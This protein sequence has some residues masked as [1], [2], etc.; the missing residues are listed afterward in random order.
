MSVGRWIA[1]LAV[2]VL[3]V[4]VVLATNSSTTQETTSSTTQ[5]MTSST[6]T[7]AT[8]STTEE[9]F[10]PD[11]ALARLPGRLLVIQA[12]GRLINMKP[13]GT[14]RLTVAEA[15]DAV[16]ERSLPAWSPNGDR[17]AWVDRFADEQIFLVIATASGEA[18]SRFKLALVPGYIAWR[19][20]GDMIAFIGDDGRANQVLRILDIASGEVSHLEDG[21]PLYFDWDPDG[22]FL[23]VHSAGTLSRIPVDGSEVAVLPPDGEFRVPVI[24]GEDMVVGFNRDIGEALSVANL[25]GE[26]DLDLIRY[27]TPMAF[28]ANGDGLVAILSKGSSANQELSGEVDVG[29]PILL[30]NNLQV[31]DRNTGVVS[32]LAEGEGVAW[33]FSR[34]GSSL[35]YLM[36][37]TVDEVQRL[38]WSLWDGNASTEMS[39]FSPSGRFGRD[40]LAFFDQFSRNTTLWSPDDSAIVYAG[41]TS[42]DDAGIWVQRVDS[43]EPVRVAVGE[44]VSWSPG[45]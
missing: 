3:I 23:L 34:D 21:A 13:D 30:P 14:N 35:A 36:E 37:E 15:D 42:I 27:A 16:A 17:V 20:T 26:V 19:P 32:Q 29:L 12:S 28:T 39:F 25:E 43:P 8:P 45:S 38:R 41:G 40:F 9:I 44:A 33:F 1:A 10:A 18:L 11:P 5:E 31:I 24:E 22:E 2:A 4:V 6:T 7:V